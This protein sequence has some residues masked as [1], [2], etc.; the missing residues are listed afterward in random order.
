[1]GIIVSDDV[2]IPWNVGIPMAGSPSKYVRVCILK[3][4]INTTME[5]VEVIQEIDFELLI[6]RGPL[7]QRG[8]A[9]AF[10]EFHSIFVWCECSSPATAEFLLLIEH[11]SYSIQPALFEQVLVI[12]YMKLE[13]W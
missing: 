13:F 4:A 11:R 10:A 7:Y 5:S 3:T 8:K 9:R 6:G 1:V 2:C 12:L